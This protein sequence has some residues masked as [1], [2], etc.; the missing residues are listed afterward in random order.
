MTAEPELATE[1]RGLFRYYG[2]P[3]SYFSAK[4]RPALSYKNIYHAEILASPRVY[5][6]VILPRTGLAFIPVL[7]TPEGETLQDTSDILDALERRIPYPALYPASPVQR[8]VAYILEI[9]ADEFMLLPAMHYRWSF[10]ESEAKVRGDFAALGG[11]PVAAGGFADRMKGSLPLLGISASTAPAIESH[12]R[13]LLDLLSSQLMDHA[14]LLGGRMSLADCAL[15]GP[16]F[17]HLYQDAAP[18]KLLRE[19]AP[20]VCHWIERVNHPDPDEKGEWLPGD[21]LA[22]ALREL[23]CLV[24]ADAVPVILDTVRAFESWADARSA[25]LAEP[26]RAVGS[27]QTALRG[28]EFERFTS[29]YTL[30]MLQRVL[31][32]YRGLTPVERAGVERELAGSGCEA[33]LSYAPRHRLEK[34]KFKLVFQ[35]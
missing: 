35:E 31:D 24:G 22:P 32:A 27:H 9:Y 12:T 8:L 18:G 3:I 14:F 6:E 28:V 16:L 4:V 11:D 34:Q 33:L 1:P 30:W 5:R 25:G 17:G 21:E 13:E 26:P 23:L 15:M 20:L 2:A 7:V 10:P 29:A 19:T